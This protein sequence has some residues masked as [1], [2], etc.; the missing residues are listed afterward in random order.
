MLFCVGEATESR[1]RMLSTIEVH[2]T[3]SDSE[4]LA[5]SKKCDCPRADI[6]L[7]LCSIDLV[8]YVVRNVVNVEVAG[9][10]LLQV[11]L[12]R[13]VF[14]EIPRHVVLQGGFPN[15]CDIHR[16]G[17]VDAAEK[18]RGEGARSDFLHG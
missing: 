11:V 14:G 6:L 4:A 9:A 1:D 7:Q 8:E 13:E 15:R 12:R 3:S 2:L 18:E 16:E 10:I 5:I 17:G